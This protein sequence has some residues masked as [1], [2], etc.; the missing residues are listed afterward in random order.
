MISASAKWCTVRLASPI[1]LISGRNKVRPLS[2]LRV[3]IMHLIIDWFRHQFMRW[4]NSG[5]T[6]FH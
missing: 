3:L 2:N 4:F 1:L 6:V 5:A